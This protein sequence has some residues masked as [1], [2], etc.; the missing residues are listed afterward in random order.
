[1][2]YITITSLA[3]REL[4]RLSLFANTRRFASNVKVSG[5]RRRDRLEHGAI[6]L[7]VEERRSN[8]DQID[9]AL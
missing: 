1:V 6:G 9:P 3:V 7:D 2:A 4:R 5:L 8:T